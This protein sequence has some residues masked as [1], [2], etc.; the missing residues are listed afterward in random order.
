MRRN[1]VYGFLQTRVPIQRGPSKDAESVNS[2]EL[3]SY[4]IPSHHYVL[5]SSQPF[6]PLHFSLIDK[7]QSPALKK[8]EK[9]DP[10]TQ[11][12][13]HFLFIIF[14][15]L[16]LLYLLFIFIY[17]YMKWF[18][19]PSLRFRKTPQ[20][21]DW[22]KE[23]SFGTLF[24]TESSWRQTVNK[25]WK[26]LLRNQNTWLEGS[27]NQQWPE[28]ILSSLFRKKTVKSPSRP[29]RFNHIRSS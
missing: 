14:T 8:R 15:I 13:F 7:F 16:L 18:N 1:C 9:T 19:Y 12:P 21:G 6:A 20:R 24:C 2:V 25:M 17:L 27:R 22:G 26:S 29:N 11:F 28:K 3:C 5:F 23:K 10:I 4:M